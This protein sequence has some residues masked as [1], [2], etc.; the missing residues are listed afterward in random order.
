M[1]YPD[2]YILAIES[3][4]DDTGASVLK[5]SNVLSNC[6]A[7]QDI[8]KS[9]GG[10]VPELASRAHQSNIVPVVHEALTNANIDKKELSAIA[11]TRGPGLLGSLLVG[12]S[13]SKSF[14]LSLKIPLIEVN[15]M[16]AHLLVHFIK[17]SRIASPAF[18]FIGVTLSGGHTQIVLVKNHFD[19]EVI[20]TT[21]D[22]AIGEA[23]DKCGKT[24][25]L[26]YP[27]GK[28]LDELAKDGDPER[29]LFPVSK[30]PLLDVSYSGIKTSFINFIAKNLTKDEAFIV[31]NLNDICASLQKS[32]VKNIMAKIEAAVL[33]YKINTVVIGGGVSA[34][35]EIK[36]QLT[37]K[38]YSKKW[39]VHIPPLEFTTDNAAMIGIVGFLKFKNKNFSTLSELASAK[40]KL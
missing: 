26:K 29:F 14:A 3:S 28:E 16:Q 34:N 8:H 19:M 15:H 4:C 6:I 23:Y 9:Y 12:S 37:K 25:G 2:K 1:L 22:D 33:L 35:S 40:L 30:V 36:K 10:V 11:Y 32:L 38:A 5:N 21:L 17:D 24:L 18:P 7:N 39:N 27:A 20:G 31:N 13:F